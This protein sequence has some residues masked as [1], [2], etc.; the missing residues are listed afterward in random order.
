MPAG[1]DLNARE[2]AKKEL[3]AL[4]VALGRANRCIESKK[5]ALSKARGELADSKAQVEELNTEIDEL[6]ERLEGAEN[7]MSQYR[8]WWLNEVQFTK[9]IL[10]KV[11]N[12]NQDWDL[13]RTSQS[14]YLGRF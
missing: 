7:Q 14:H 2:Q 9:L 8:N 4:T 5:K 1:D 12:A 6:K 13:V 3:E 11:P 10:N